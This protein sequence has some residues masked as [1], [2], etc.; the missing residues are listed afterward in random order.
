MLLG[1]YKITC[2][3]HQHTNLPDVFSTTASLTFLAGVPLKIQVCL[4]I[5]QNQ[6]GSNMGAW[7]MRAPGNQD[8]GDSRSLLHPSSSVQPADS[9]IM[10]ERAITQ[11]KHLIEL[12]LLNNRTSK[13][14]TASFS[15]ISHRCECLSLFFFLTALT[16]HFQ[17]RISPSS[18]VSGSSGR[19]TLKT[20]RKVNQKAREMKRQYQ[21]GERYLTN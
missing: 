8:C 20:E 17:F 21:N 7:D 12:S 4:G 16:F 6:D 5:N 3:H 2:P 9:K 14:L 15:S 1:P 19:G 18:S 10:V 11:R 13:L